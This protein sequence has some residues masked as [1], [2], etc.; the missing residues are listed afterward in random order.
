MLVDGGL[1]DK[2][3]DR[4]SNL[5]KK[6]AYNSRS[7]L[8]AV[9]GKD[10]VGTVYVSYDGWE[11]FIYRLAV[12]HTF[13]EKGTGTLLMRSAERELRRLGAREVAIFVDAKNSGLHKYYK[14][15]G[16]KLSRMWRSMWKRL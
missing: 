11:G 15:R 10:V 16:Y 1:F 2:V 3:W 7:V 5:S 13:R 8:V 14:K 12:L 9:S 4:R 6:R